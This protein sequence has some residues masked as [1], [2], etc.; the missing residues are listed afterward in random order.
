MNQTKFEVKLYL[1]FK[2][3]SI[4]AV[5][6]NNHMETL[7]ESYGIKGGKNL[8]SSCVGFGLERLSF[9]ILSQYGFDRGNWPDTLKEDLVL[10]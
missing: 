6:I 2:Q 3:Q 5:S 9:S 10:E 8:I 7:T 1:P 4:S